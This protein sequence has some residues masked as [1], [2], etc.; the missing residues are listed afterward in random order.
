MNRCI[1]VAK[2]LWRQRQHSHLL[3]TADSNRCYCME[4]LCCQAR[5]QKRV[6]REC[7]PHDSV[8]T[9]V[10]SKL[11]LHATP[12]SSQHAHITIHILS[13]KRVT[14]LLLGLFLRATY[15]TVSVRFSDWY[16]RFRGVLQELCD[17]ICMIGSPQRPNLQRHVSASVYINIERSLLSVFLSQG[18]SQSTKARVGGFLTRLVSGRSLQH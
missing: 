8:S 4:R 3:L 2:L 1:S 12:S 11:F 18:C 10:K 17:G 6:T 5:C 16:L 9:N 14:P 13:N 15:C 7:W